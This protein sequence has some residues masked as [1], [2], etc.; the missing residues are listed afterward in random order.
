[1]P[2]IPSMEK[3]SATSSAKPV[4][5]T[6]MDVESGENERTRPPSWE[7]SGGRPPEM[8]IFQY[9]FLDGCNFLHFQHFQNQ[10]AEILEQI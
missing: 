3:K 2:Q 7:I 4:S 5:L 10:V 9:F 6:Y 8:L 1:M